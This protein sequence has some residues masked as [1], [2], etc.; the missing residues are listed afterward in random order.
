VPVSTLEFEQNGQTI[1]FADATS[2][3]TPLINADLYD[4]DPTSN[5]YQPI[6]AG[7]SLSSGAGYWIDADSPVTLIFPAPQ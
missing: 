3:D 1:S 2:G 5:S 6:T 4:Y 7:Q